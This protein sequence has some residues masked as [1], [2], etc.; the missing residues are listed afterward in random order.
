MK[1][2]KINNRGFTLVELMIV[3]AIIGVLAATLLPRLQGAQERSRDTG[4]LSSLSQTQA[5]L[6]T[7]FSDYSSY[8]NSPASTSD[9]NSGDETCLSASDWTVNDAIAWLFKWNKAPTDPQRTNASHPCTT[10][11]SFW[12]AALQKNGIVGGWYA[13]TA[14]V[15]ADNKAN[16]NASNVIAS[17]VD[18]DT[19]QTTTPWS[20]APWSEPTANNSIFVHS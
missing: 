12:Y 7:Y 2:Q 1:L 11:W 6:E 15:E 20:F 5:V 8:P 13:L 3:I 9:I 4:R 18:F 10:A 19:I 16:Y 14:N 17:G